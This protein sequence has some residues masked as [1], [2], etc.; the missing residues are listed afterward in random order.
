MTYPRA[1]MPAGHGELVAHPPVDEWAALARRN[2]E[3]ITG[4]RFTVAGE[5]IGALRERARRELLALASGETGRLGLAAPPVP[6][7]PGPVIVTGHQPEFCH[8]GVWVKDFLLQRTARESAGVGIDLVV[9]SDVFETLGVEAPR[10]TVD[11][12]RTSH[13]LARGGPET[14]FACAPAPSADELERFCESV[15][16]ALSTLPAPAVARHFSRYCDAARA[17]L[18]ASRSLAEF[19]VG[20]RRRYEGDRSDYLELPVTAAARSDA[21]RAFAVDIVL[22]ARRFAEAY[23]AELAAYRSLNKVRSDAQPFPDLQ[24]IDTDVELPF[25]LLRQGR[26]EAVFARPEGHAVEVRTAAGPVAALPADRAGAREALA[27]SGVLLAPRAATLTLF[28]RGLL[29]DLFIHGIGG[30]RYDRV[31]EGLAERWWGVRLPRHAVASLTM[32]LPLGVPVDAGARLSEVEH[33]LHR[34]AHNPDDALGEVEFETAAEERL[35][36]E[37]AEEKREL[38]E[39]I[40]AP[41][42]DRKTLGMRIRVINE[43]LARA[44]EPLAAEYRAER[45]QLVRQQAE[46]EVL[47]D[48]TYPFCFWSPA[49]ISDTV[50]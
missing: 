37:L 35:A 36:R 10:F 49:E 19:M 39:R 26:R 2:A 15:G 29:A 43:E 33:R 24:T 27:G 38:V 6:P 42:A 7:D 50:F 23:N 18:P 44:V 34:L 21:F 11:V 40:S 14:C 16:A 46:A 28:A 20:A 13:L 41:G 48:R 17:A 31:T 12:T 22:E 25:W 45:E 8:A 5:P 30:D 3:E 47:T 32:L 9:D 1:E 4:W